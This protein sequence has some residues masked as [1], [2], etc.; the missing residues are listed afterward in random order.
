M[1]CQ[2]SANGWCFDIGTYGSSKRVEACKEENF[3][4]GNNNPEYTYVV[5]FLAQNEPPLKD[6]M[7]LTRWLTGFVS[8]PIERTALYNWIKSQL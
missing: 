4:A 5:D 2:Y 1:Y 3:M 6:V 8:D 7:F